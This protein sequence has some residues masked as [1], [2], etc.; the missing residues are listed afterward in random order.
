MFKDIND[1]KTKMSIQIIKERY[2]DMLYLDTYL[3]FIYNLLERYNDMIIMLDDLDDR[4][5]QKKIETL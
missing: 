2:S 5:C 3:P 1:V 4:E